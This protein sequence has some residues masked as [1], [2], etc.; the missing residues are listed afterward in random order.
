MSIDMFIDI[1]SVSE[2]HIRPIP[3]DLIVPLFAVHQLMSGDGR[4][5][6]EETPLKGK[7]EKF[8]RRT[9]IGSSKPAMTPVL[10]VKGDL[11]TA[12]N[13]SPN[14]SDSLECNDRVQ[15]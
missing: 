6:A 2:L 7:S 5:A 1:V 12:D 11:I 13:Q 9:Y 3:N 15:W 8:G 10:R 4:E 14:P